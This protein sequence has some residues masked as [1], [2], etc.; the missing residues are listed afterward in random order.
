MAARSRTD[1]MLALGILVA[2]VVGVVVVGALGS[3]GADPFEVR[4]SRAAAICSMSI[5]SLRTLRS[6]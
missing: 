5:P 1:G 6:K 3:R 2:L 4:R